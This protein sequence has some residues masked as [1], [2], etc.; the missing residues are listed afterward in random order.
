MVPV[1]KNRDEFLEVNK[2]K[3]VCTYVRTCVCMC[4]CMLAYVYMYVCVGTYIYISCHMCKLQCTYL[5]RSS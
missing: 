3:S 4:V 5:T 2:R 1:I